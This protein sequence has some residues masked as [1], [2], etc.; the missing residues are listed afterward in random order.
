MNDD[1]IGGLIFLALLGYGGWWLYDTY[2]AAPPTYDEQV[3][4]LDETLAVQSVGASTDYWIV[5]ANSLGPNDRVALIFGM[6]DDFTFCNA[7]ADALTA[8]FRPD[9]YICMAAN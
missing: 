8:R 6:L 7:A 1:G 2:L 4:A 5:K 3:A 9:Q